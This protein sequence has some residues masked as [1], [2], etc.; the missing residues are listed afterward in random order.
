[1]DFLLTAKREARCQQSGRRGLQSRELHVGSGLVGV[2]PTNIAL[3]S[4]VGGHDDNSTLHYNGN[5][6]GFIALPF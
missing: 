5:A 2:V 1:V 4:R 3:I 6:G